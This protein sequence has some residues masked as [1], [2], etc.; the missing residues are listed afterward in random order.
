MNRTDLIEI[1]DENFGE[2]LE[3]A[4]RHTLEE[5]KAGPQTGR[6]LLYMLEKLVYDAEEIALEMDYQDAFISK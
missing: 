2:C 3:D 4:V 5:Y 1:T 6:R